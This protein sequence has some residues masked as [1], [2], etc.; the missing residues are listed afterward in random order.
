MVPVIPLPISAIQALV[1]CANV[2]S[3]YVLAA[4]ETDW[5]Y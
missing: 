1:L 5:S 3:G 2:V 4:V